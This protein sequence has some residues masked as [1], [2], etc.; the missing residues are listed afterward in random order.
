MA[1]KKNEKPT[2]VILADPAMAILPGRTMTFSTTPPEGRASVKIVTARQTKITTP[3]VSRERA[4]VSHIV[5]T[6]DDTIEVTFYDDGKAV[7]TG[8]WD[9]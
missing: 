1:K 6:G 4:S 3:S 7:A 2:G 8:T 9:V 5:E